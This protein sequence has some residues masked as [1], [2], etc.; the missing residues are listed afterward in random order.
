MSLINKMLQ[1]LDKRGSPGTDG[2]PADI[3]PVGRGE[4]AVPLPLVM[5]ALAGVLILGAGA[6]IGWRFLHQQPVAPLAVPSASVAQV[7]ISPPEQLPMPEAVQVP[8]VATVATTPPPQ[9]LAAVVEKA[10]PAAR[11]DELAQVAAVAEKVAPRAKPVAHKDATPGA[12]PREANAAP[13]KDKPAV[14]AAHAK[15][16]ALAPQEGRQALGG[17]GAEGAYRRALA[18]LQEGRVTEAVAQLEQ[19]LGIDARHEAARQTLVGIL[20]EQRRSD[21]AM[22]LLQAGLALD[23]RQPAM[24]MLLARMQIDS[25]ASGV[26][27]LMASLP[28]AVGNGE[29]HGFL[30]GALQRERRHQEAVE[31]YQAA[32]RGTPDNSVWWMGLGI[33]LEAEQRLPEALAAFQRARAAGN[34]A[35]ELQG[36]VERKVGALGR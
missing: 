19:A 2:A 7:V 26:G 8:Q 18:A 11:Q 33:S 14:P 35:P 17:Q 22:R 25:G 28:A 9:Q 15:T 6:A 5:G 3:R 23:A 13:V 12:P 29:Y 34:L 4:R 21:E 32:L 20:I 36:F 27:T 16:V 1:D 24:A 10:K 31:Q 30:A